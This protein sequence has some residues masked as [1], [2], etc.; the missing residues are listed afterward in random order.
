MRTCWYGGVDRYRETLDVTLLTGKQALVDEM[1]NTL[2]EVYAVLVV[3]KV[4]VDTPVNV[5]QHEL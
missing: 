1:G 3:S 5:V 4:K 2:A